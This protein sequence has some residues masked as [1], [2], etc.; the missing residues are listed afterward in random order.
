MNVSRFLTQFIYIYIGV[1]SVALEPMFR[2]RLFQ[3]ETL[4][5]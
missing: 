3:R 2:A 4:L 1:L 5:N